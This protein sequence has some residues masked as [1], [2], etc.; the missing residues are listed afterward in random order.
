MPVASLTVW[1]TV[2]GMSVTIPQTLYASGNFN[3]G[4][5]GEVDLSVG[6]PLD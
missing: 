6:A 4:R 1:E 5:F 2:E 3:Q